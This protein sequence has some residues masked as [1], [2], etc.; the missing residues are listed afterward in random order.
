MRLKTSAF[1]PSWHLQLCHGLAYEKPSGWLLP[2][3]ETGQRTLSVLIVRFSILF[4]IKND[5]SKKGDGQDS[6]GRCSF[7]DQNDSSRRH[8]N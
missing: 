5:S 6:R 3:P 1:T 4:A 2:S 7:P 8:G